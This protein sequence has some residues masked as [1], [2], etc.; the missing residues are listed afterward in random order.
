MGLDGRLTAGNWPQAEESKL[1]KDVF[2]GRRGA[3]RFD[4][5]ADG[6]PVAERAGEAESGRQ[7]FTLLRCLS[8]FST[9]NG[10]TSLERHPSS[11]RRRAL[12][13]LGTTRDAPCRVAD[14]AATGGNVL[15]GPR[16]GLRVN[17]GFGPVAFHAGS[18]TCA[19][20]QN[21]PRQSK[22]PQDRRMGLI[23]RNVDHRPRLLCVDRLFCP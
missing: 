8:R 4:T 20:V 6:E 16:G 1:N 23:Q 15:G 22:L 5:V 3:S 2:C 13:S 11:P 18:I 21:Y 14:D 19:L 10:R 17:C 7:R 9:A 12:V